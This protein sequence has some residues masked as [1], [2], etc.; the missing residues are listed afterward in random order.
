MLD[1]KNTLQNQH[2]YHACELERKY[3]IFIRRKTNKTV[4]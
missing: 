3:Y 1:Y 2:S 4:C